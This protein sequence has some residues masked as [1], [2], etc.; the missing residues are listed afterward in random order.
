MSEETE[1][2]KL[3]ERHSELCAKAH[4][5]KIELPG[6]LIFDFDTVEAGRAICA[7][8][9]KLVAVAPEVEHTVKSAKTPKAPAKAKSKK[10]VAEA[11]A[12]QESD[13]MAKTAKKTAAA[14]P[15]KKTAKKATVKKAAKKAGAKSNGVA[16]AV[17][18]GGR[19][20]GSKAETLYK[21]LTSAKGLTS[22]EGAKAT[23]W[24][25]CSLTMWAKKFGLKVTKVK[26]KDGSTRYLGK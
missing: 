14:K 17:G 10:P 19:R 13:T 24:K 2:Q 3:R 21:M 15:A 6:D 5:L 8:I 4:T 9:E 7:S 18:A 16:K 12:Q 26:Q 23:G 11:S 1:L 22:A 20:A 25:T